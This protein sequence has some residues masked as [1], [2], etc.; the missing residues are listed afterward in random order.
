MH[1]WMGNLFFRGATPSELEAMSF[2]R[3]R[4]WNRWHELMVKVKPGA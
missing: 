1:Q 3:M 4:Y 2:E